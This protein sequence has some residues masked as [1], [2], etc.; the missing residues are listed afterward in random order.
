[1]AEATQYTVTNRELVE[2]IIRHADIHDGKW[3][4]MAAFG[5]APGNFGPTNDKLVPGTIV[6][7]QNVGISRAEP[8]TPPEMTVDASVVNPRPKKK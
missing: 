6:A 5:F 7:I 1:M 3:I 2:L 8:N 4:M